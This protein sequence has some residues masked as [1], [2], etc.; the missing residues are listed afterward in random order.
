MAL[1]AGASAA[2]ATALILRIGLAHGVQ[3]HVDVT[4]TSVTV[5]CPGND[6]GDAP[7]TLVRTVPA[8][9]LDY[10]RLGHPEGVVRAVCVGGLGLEEA[11]LAL[12]E[13][14]AS[15]DEYRRWVVLLAAFTQGASICALLGGVALEMT[16]AG[17]ATLLI[18]VLNDQLTRRNASY[19][20]AQ[21]AA[22]A[23]PT[24]LRLP[25]HPRQG[26]GTDHEAEQHHPERNEGDGPD[27]ARHRPQ[28]EER[29]HDPQRPDAQQ[30]PQQD[31][32]QATA[33][34]PAAAG[35]GSRRAT[36]RATAPARQPRPAGSHVHG[37]LSCDTYPPLTRPARGPIAKVST[38]RSRP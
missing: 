20:F 11:N 23:I 38:T 30:H 26:E 17:L 6:D 22:G 18:G 7:T 27:V 15:G 2:E 8:L 14:G 21:V 10:A 29:T 28:Q 9:G 5:S 16:A 31:V 36:P 25:E 34:A 32:H 12:K 33:S 19:F 3:L 1:V 35:A 4:Y 13:R 24:A 37:L